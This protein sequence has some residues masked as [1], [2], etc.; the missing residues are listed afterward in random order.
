MH[1]VDQRLLNLDVVGLDQ[2]QIGFQF[3]FNDDAVVAKFVREHADHFIDN[4]VHIKESFDRCGLLEEGT[5]SPQYFGRG[6]AVPDDPI[7]RRL[8]PLEIRRIVR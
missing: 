5:N 7:E 6:M 4:L 2:R 8:R 1:Q 3:R